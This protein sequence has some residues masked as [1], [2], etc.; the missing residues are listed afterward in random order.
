VA[1][2]VALELLLRRLAVIDEGIAVALPVL[3]DQDLHVIGAVAPLGL[4]VVNHRV[5]ERADM[6][7]GL[8]RAGVLD[9]R[10]VEADDLHRA[11]VGP[12][13]G[14]LDHVA[15]PPVADV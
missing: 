9:D 3:G 12:E 11:P 2:T 7:A 14:A 1:A 4:A 5:I 8:P 15:P 13:R 6:P 10:R